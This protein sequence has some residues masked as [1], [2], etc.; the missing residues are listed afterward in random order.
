MFK[1]DSI[2]ISTSLFP[3]FIPY[4]IQKGVRVSLEA[5]GGPFNVYHG[6]QNRGQNA[7]SEE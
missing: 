7:I 3:Y 4:F 5:E 2:E 6:G 1:K